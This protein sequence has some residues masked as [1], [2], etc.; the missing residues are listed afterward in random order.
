[1]P[2]WLRQLLPWLVATAILGFLLTQVPIGD[3]WEATRAARL[4]I[5]FPMVLFCVTAWFLLDSFAFSY[6]FSRFNAPLSWAEARALRGTTYLLT[7]INWNLGTAGIVLHLRR[8]KQIGAV[9]SSS[10]MLFYM[11]IDTL[12]L[13]ALA[14][15]GL[16]LLPVSAETRTLRDGTL[17]L[18]LGVAGFLALFLAPLPGWAW[19]ERL[20]GI[21]LFRTHGLASVRDVGLLL[22]LRS[23]YF[24]GFAALFWVGCEAFGVSL[25]LELVAA[26]TPPILAS[27]VL[28]I[29]PAGLGTQQATMLYFFARHGNEA[30]VLAFGLAFPVAVTLGRCL[31]GLRYLGTLRKLRTTTA[32]E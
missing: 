15:I 18:V 25:P 8:S 6:L 19:L 12:V 23:V 5:F 10:T 27:A 17:V 31:L 26:S 20:R 11:V 16:W 30:A 9:D 29:T 28:P 32:P 14:L 13:S 22:G 1:M 2:R 4:E 21:G 7:P 24:A 3:A